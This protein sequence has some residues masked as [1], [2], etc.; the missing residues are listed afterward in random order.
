MFSNVPWGDLYADDLVI[1]ASWKTFGLE[2]GYREEGA[3]SV[4]GEVSKI[5]IMI[6]GTGLDLLQSSG[7]FPC[8]LCHLPQ[9]AAT[10]LNTTLVHN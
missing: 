2:G 10:V 5:M 1:I 9:Q 7:K 3:E 8:A 4:C 6:S